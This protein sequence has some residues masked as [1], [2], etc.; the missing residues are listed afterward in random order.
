[1]AC[2]EIQTAARRLREHQG[3]T[4]AAHSIRQQQQHRIKTTRDIVN[5]SFHATF[6]HLQTCNEKA[7]MQ[8][9]TLML[10]RSLSSSNES[11]S[12]PWWFHTLLRDTSTS[13][14]VQEGVNAEW[15]FLTSTSSQPPIQMCAMEKISSK[16][17]RRVFCKL[18]NSTD[19]R[20][21]CPP[22]YTIPDTI[23]K[24]VFLRDPLERFLSAFMDKCLKRRIEGHCEPTSVFDNHAIEN[25][26][27]FFEAFVD[28]MPLHWNVHFFPQ[29]WV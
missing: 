28:S 12:I 26:R 21:Y 14:S 16:Q 22:E 27:L 23:S 10:H 11:P 9:C 25:N 3:A 7:T 5:E 17:W 24:F 6:S 4:A 15:H 19:E 29:R 13:N 1:M 2:L 18:Q 20:H 8:G